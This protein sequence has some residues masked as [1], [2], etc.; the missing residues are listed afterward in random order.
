MSRNVRHSQPL[1]RRIAHRYRVLRLLGR[2][3]LGAAL[4]VRDEALGVERCLKLV[5]S[6]TA[7]PA[8]RL[9]L[10][11]EFKL[12][13]GLDHP[14]L[15]AVHD[16][17]VTQL[18]REEAFF[19]TAD[20]VRGISLDRYAAGASFEQLRAALLGPLGALAYLHRAGIRHGDIK[21]EN[22][23]VGDAGGVL[24][25]LSCSARIGQP[26][27][28][29]LSG[30]L[31]FLA[32]ELMAGEAGDARADLY[33]IGKLLLALAELS[34]DGL[35]APVLALARRL[36]EERPEQRPSEV[37]EVLE[38]LGA[39]AEQ[40]HP[41]ARKTSVIVGR[42]EELARGERCLDALVRGA[43]GPR[44]LRVVGPK[45][46]GK[47]RLLRE[48]T[49]RAE[50]RCATVEGFARAGG[51]GDRR[52]ARPRARGGRRGLGQLGG[53]A[54]APRLARLAH[55]ARRR[56]DRGAFTGRS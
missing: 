50:L 11:G 40:L 36:A 8:R 30:T 26:S 14:S 32:P 56:R 44:S 17:G 12:L 24:L 46:S 4:L 51:R 45:G 13:A 20:F 23:L 48:L 21:P 41:R 27:A 37:R 42:D 10:E 43:P 38:A 3:G 54:R 39:S 31:G 2:G 53:E 33:A 6:H 18:E 15:A 25:D 1:P 52:D 55:R 9:A 19:F 29:G 28:L 47:S 35:P 7:D 49:W 16:F 5:E 34:A 22:I